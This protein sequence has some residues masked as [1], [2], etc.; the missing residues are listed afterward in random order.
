M[1]QPGS[2]TCS[3]KGVPGVMTTKTIL[4]QDGQ[5]CVYNDEVYTIRN[6]GTAVCDLFR[7]GKLVHTEVWLTNLKPLPAVGVPAP[8]PA[9]SPRKAREYKAGGYSCERCPDLPPFETS[10]QKAIH[11]RDHHKEQ[12]KDTSDFIFPLETPGIDIRQKAALLLS[13][14]ENYDKTRPTNEPKSTREI[15]VLSWLLED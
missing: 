6:C 11:V 13:W 10:I 3:Q 12:S 2:P 4:W 1:D 5:Q 7:V 15:R 14:L 9:D 8:K